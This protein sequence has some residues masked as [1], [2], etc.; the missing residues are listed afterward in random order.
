MKTEKEEREQKEDQMRRIKTRK[1]KKPTCGIPT[2]RPF[3]D[4]TWGR[5]MSEQGTV[6]ASLSSTPLIISAPESNQKW[7]T[8]TNEKEAHSLSQSW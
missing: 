5:A 4:V 2:R 1:K 8:I 3:S 6:V 7:R